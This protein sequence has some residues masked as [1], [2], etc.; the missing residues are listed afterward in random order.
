MTRAASVR[1]APLRRGTLDAALR[2]LLQEYPAAFV[3]AIDENGLFV[4]MPASVPLTGQELLRARSMLELVIPQDRELVIATW[5]R[6]RDTGASSA[7][8]HLTH[9]ADHLAVIHY[10]NAQAQ[11][12]VY[13]GVL[14]GGDATALA[15]RPEVVPYRPRIARV[16]KNELA[17]FLEVDDAT[18]RI[19]GWA[20]SDLV[21]H[22]SLEFLHPE[23]QDRAI[24]SWMQLLSEPDLEQARCRCA[25][26]AL[27]A[28]GS[29]SR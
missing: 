4:P 7:Q 13:L 24:E 15:A 1:P 28:G 9:D 12:G 5:E 2:A 22:R 26:A 17:V 29:G 16:R 14:V 18:T 8:V 3:A 21:G 11:H 6:A 25:T 27:M 20:A 10:L 19:L 23:D